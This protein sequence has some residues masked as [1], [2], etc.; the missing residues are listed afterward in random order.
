MEC[1][2]AEH[3]FDA[4]TPTQSPPD[5]GNEQDAGNAV[6]TKP[7]EIV[8]KLARAGFTA[9]RALQ[10]IGHNP[11]RMTFVARHSFTGG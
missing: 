8:A 5:T 3:L 2:E 10:N 11:W 7:E 9:S 1:P 4:D 6:P